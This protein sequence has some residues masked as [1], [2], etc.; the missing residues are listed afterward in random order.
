M[1]YNNPRPAPFFQQRQT[2]TRNVLGVS[3]LNLDFPTKIGGYTFLENTSFKT[4]LNRIITTLNT[5]GTIADDSVTFAKIQNIPTT[6]LIGRSTAGTGDPESITIGS[7]LSLSGGTLSAT[8]SGMAIGNSITSATAGSVLFAG[9]SGILQQDN[10]NLFWDDANNKLG[11]GTSTINGVL[12]IHSGSNT[13]LKLTTSGSGTAST[14]GFDLLYSS[15]N[16]GYV[17][18]RENEALNFMTNNTERGRFTNSGDL[19]VGGT[20]AVTA[21]ARLHVRGGGTTSSTINFK[22]ENSAGSNL[23]SIRDD[24]SIL[25]GTGN[26]N[27]LFGVYDGSS[28][29]T[30]GAGFALTGGWGSGSGYDVYILNNQGSG[31]TGTG[32]NLS[33]TGTFA[34]TSGAIQPINVT[35]TF[36]A[37][38]GSANYRPL[39]I[40]YTINNSGAQSG[41][42]TGIFLNATETALNSMT[43]NVMDLQVGGSSIFK[44]TRT[45]Q[46][47][48]SSNAFFNG[49]I[50][51]G[52]A[53]AIQ[54]SSG[55]ALFSSSD[56]V[57]RMTDNVGTSF[58]RLQFGG[59]TAAFPSI[60]RNNATIQIRLAD[61]SAAADLYA[62]QIGAGL[63]SNTSTLQTAGSLGL[64][65]NTSSGAVT[66]DSTRT[67]YVNT[68]SAVTW[69]LPAVSGNTD[70]IYF[71]KNRGS[72]AITLNANGGATEIYTTSAVTTMTINAGEAFIL[73]NDG[74]YW[75]VI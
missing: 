31:R 72:G 66:L 38:A 75:N 50:S 68:G 67:V 42:A 18:V 3:N 62:A 1:N 43:H 36:A 14:D 11:I 51:A 52:G 59:T 17:I 26:N 39:S 70:R 45:G 22:T 34:A 30:L 74:T 40:A 56:G 44:V 58:N 7:G 71:I 12:H 53:S 32:G 27:P 16:G 41:T 73:T 19:F 21:A 8:S 49:I 61:D 37:A 5:G 4:V 24:N 65:T 29:G 57:I 15:S 28:Y 55:S 33:I 6:T 63:T 47:N 48:T 54:W 60:K 69:T 64:K 9:T 23:F 20:S 2:G 25:F 35:S 46:I 13:V 10:A